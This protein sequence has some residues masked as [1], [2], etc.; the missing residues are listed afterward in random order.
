MPTLSEMI[1]SQ[2]TLSAQDVEWLHLLVGDWQVVADLAF[3]DLVL[4]LPAT[5]ASSWPSPTAAR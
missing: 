2:S 3:S 4:W 1:G 5:T